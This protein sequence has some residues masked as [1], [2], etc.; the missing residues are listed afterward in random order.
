MAETSG[1]AYIWVAILGL[2]LSTIGVVVGLAGY[3]YNVGINLIYLGL[4]VLLFSI[5]LILNSKK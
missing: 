4:A 1:V 5:A 3:W 2:I